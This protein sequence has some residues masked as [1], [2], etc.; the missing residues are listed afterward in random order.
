GEVGLILQTPTSVLFII[1][2]SRYWIIGTTDTPWKQDLAHPVAT[3]ADIDY[4]LDQANAVLA[5]PIGREDIVGHYAGLRPLLQPGTN[6]EGVSAKISREHTVAS[7]APGMVS[8]A[9][10]KFTTYRVMA[11]DAVDFALGERAKR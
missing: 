3:A 9:G 2:W 4:V 11:M 8:I 7:P 10:G 6:S 1:P 5:R